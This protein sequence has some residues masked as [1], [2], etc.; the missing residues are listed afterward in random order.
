MLKDFCIKY[1]TEDYFYDRH[2]C[3]RH[4][5]YSLKIILSSISLL[6]C[7]SQFSDIFY[8]FINKLKWNKLEELWEHAQKC[9]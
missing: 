2:I 1:G 7:L 3:Y 5:R 4:Y 6:S 8:D 9:T